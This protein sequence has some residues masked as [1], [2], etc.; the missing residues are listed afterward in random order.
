MIKHLLFALLASF[1]PFSI[2]K[3]KGVIKGSVPSIDTKGSVEKL[4]A[5]EIA[6]GICERPLYVRE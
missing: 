5:P 2:F 4:D 3:G 6:I 1:L